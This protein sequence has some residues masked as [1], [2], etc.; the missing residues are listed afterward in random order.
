MFQ[1]AFTSKKCL[2]V[3]L[4]NSWTFRLVFCRVLSWLSLIVDFQTTQHLSSCPKS[5]LNCYSGIFA[6]HLIS[7]KCYW[8]ILQSFSVQKSLKNPLKPLGAIFEISFNGYLK[9]KWDFGWWTQPLQNSLHIVS[10]R[11]KMSRIV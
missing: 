5:F 2:F 8:G 11:P 4:V 7:E 1:I 10:D 6:L 9:C 3:F